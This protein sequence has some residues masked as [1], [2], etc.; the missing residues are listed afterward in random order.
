MMFD[1]EAVARHFDVSRETLER[2][3]TLVHQVGRWQRAIN[4]VSRQS[5]ESIWHRHVADSA[6]LFA[7]A[8]EAATS[9]AD[10]GAGAGFPGLVIAAMAH[11]RRPHL[12]V[13]LLESDTR[14]AAFIAETARM[15]GLNVELR[16]IRVEDLPADRRFDV[17]S[18]RAL[19]PL[20]A[21]MRLAKPLRAP[22]GVLIFPKGA[23]VDAELAAL[24]P[25]DRDAATRI[26]SVTHAQATI[27]KWV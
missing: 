9:W 18:A 23:G 11:D 22:G 21:L 6:Q 15:M 4:L 27:L 7:L 5:L 1:R 13:A 26:P 20:L 17:V 16:A 25:I 3:D 14:K 10:L 2:L 24:E 19:A 12:K 8:P